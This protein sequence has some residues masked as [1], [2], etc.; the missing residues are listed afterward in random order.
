M[1]T[2]TPV[3]PARKATQSSISKDKSPTRDSPKKAVAD[4]RLFIRQP[5]EHEWRKL[6]PAGVHEIIVKKIA[7]SPALFG[8]VKPVHSGFA[9]S[10]FS[11]EAR[12]KIPNAGNGLFLLGAKLEPATNWIPAIVPTIPATIRKEQREV[13]VSKC[14]L[15]DQIERVC[16]IRPAHVKLYGGNKPGAPNRN[17]MAYFSTAPNAS[18]RVFDGSGIARK[19]KKQQSIDFCKRCNG[20]HPTKNCSRAPSCGNCGST[21]HSEDLC[22]AAT[23]CRNCGGPHDLDSRRCLARLT[24][25]GVP[26]KEQ[27]KIYRQAGERDCYGQGEEIE[28]W[29]KENNLTCLIIG[30]STH[31]AGNTLDLAWT[32]VKEAMAW[33]A[34]EECMT[35][36]H[37]PIH[38]FVPI[39]REAA[40]DFCTSDKILVSKADLPK[41]AQAISRWIPPLIPLNTTE[42]SEYFAQNICWAL[43]N[44]LKAVGKCA[45][46][47]CG[48]SAPWW[49]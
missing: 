7:I 45:N 12:E 48:R 17:W 41:F 34:T 39:C 24:R 22:M 31:R 14:M 30:E 13:E 10:P 21:N 38:G 37:L 3:A 44:A 49:T 46:T 16:P 40:A 6:S 32:N 18:F 35:S 42:E 47:K 28:K 20:H 2:K 9:L 15:A 1:N 27:L 19:F 8:K 29:A 11:E 4:R 43:E 25:S 23:K 26:T 5:E 33:V 36:D